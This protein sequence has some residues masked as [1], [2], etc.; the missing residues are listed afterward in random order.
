MPISRNAATLLDSVAGLG[1]PEDAGFN[2]IKL[3][4]SN[5]PEVS[6]RDPKYVQGAEA[7]DFCFHGK[8]QP[9]VQGEVGFGMLPLA[10][11]RLWVEWLPGRAGFVAQHAEKPLEAH[12]DQDENGRLI[13][14]MTASG[15]V[16]E[17]TFYLICA[18]AAAN[19]LI[20]GDDVWALSLRSTGITVLRNK[21]VA[22]LNKL[23]IDVN[24]VRKQPPI[25]GSKWRVLSERTG[26]Q[27]GSWFTYRFTLLGKVGDPEGPTEEEFQIGCDLHQSFAPSALPAPPAASGR[28][29]RAR[30]P[31]RAD[32]GRISRPRPRRQAMTSR[33]ACDPSR[34]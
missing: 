22:P 12:Y 9:I 23:R 19:R 17:E 1:V 31:L 5:S 13:L 21:F 25:F 11:K 3:L 24:G 28:D 2:I 26:N 16:I 4:Q 32:A 14:R 15:N 8:E 34:R 29:R 18:I 30:S 20:D 6:R 10:I 27:E 7:G 33:P